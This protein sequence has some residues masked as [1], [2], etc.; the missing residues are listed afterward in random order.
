ML[1]RL[2]IAFIVIACFCV[3]AVFFSHLSDAYLIFEGNKVLDGEVWRILS[4]HFYHTNWSHLM[5]NL[6]GLALLMILF[7]E[8]YTLTSFLCVLGLASILIGLG[9]ILFYPANTQYLGLSG[10]LHALASAGAVMSLNAKRL[11]AVLFLIGLGVKLVYE[12]TVGASESLALMI[13]AR[14]AVEAHLI[15]A[16]SGGLFGVYKLSRQTS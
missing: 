6:L 5:M 15:G 16:L 12:F 2:Q 10:V 4:S 1:I 9:Y 14:V 8:V 7:N 11:F 13:H 3:L